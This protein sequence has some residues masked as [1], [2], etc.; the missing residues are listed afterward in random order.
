MNSNVYHNNQ[1]ETLKQKLVKTIT[2]F[3]LAPRCPGD[4]VYSECHSRCPPQC[5]KSGPDFCTT[6]CVAGCGCS[7]G[8]YRSGNKCYKKNDCPKSPG[9]MSVKKNNVLH[10]KG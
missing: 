2:I 8:L 10:Y 5:N 3:H 9:M 7:S 1:T 6:D 4:L